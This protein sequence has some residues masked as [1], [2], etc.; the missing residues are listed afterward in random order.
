M[1]IQTKAPVRI[2]LAGGTLD[3][4]PLFL[5]VPS[6]MTLSLAINLWAEVEVQYPRVSQQEG[7]SFFSEDQQKGFEGSWEQLEQSH[8]DWDHLVTL[9]PQWSVLELPVRLFLFFVRLAHSR[10]PRIRFH[11]LQVTTRA[12]SPAGA[13]L[14]GSSAL[15][16]ALAGAFNRLCLKETPFSAQDCLIIV[17]DIET[18]V[19]HSP[20]GVQDYYSALYG[21]WQA[22][23]WET[24]Q[25]RRENFYHQPPW[26]HRILLFYSG[27]SRNSGINNWAL[28]QAL[29]NRE[30]GV[31][32]LFRRIAQSACALREAILHGN[33]LGAR[34]AILSEWEARRELA[35]HIS[36]PPIDSF[37]T[38]LQTTYPGPWAYK[39]CGAGGGGCFFVI[40]P[41]GY[42]LA[43]IKTTAQQMGMRSL[44]FQED[45]NGLQIQI[46][47]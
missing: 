47:D 44:S 33:D 25:M 8:F 17:R 4:W 12:Q 39:I 18:Q 27:Q 11:S 6:P 34:Q 5:W 38:H 1:I 26:R 2:D 22:L 29:M 37:L 20:A 42:D 32:E 28:Y 41:P 40:V 31:R 9:F 14:G 23:H 43:I 10:N 24:P 15:A 36:T 7:I 13:G 45:L 16:I 30:K 3:L 46:L 19:I 21:G 35:P